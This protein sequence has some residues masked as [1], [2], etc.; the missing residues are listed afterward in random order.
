MTKAEGPPA[1][2]WTLLEPTLREEGTFPTVVLTRSAEVAAGQVGLDGSI[3]ECDRHTAHVDLGLAHTPVR[4]V[5]V[6]LDVGRRLHSLDSCVLENQL[7][8][9]EP[10]A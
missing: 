9:L 1:L 7:L 3:A 10:L 2:P 5:D 6:G 8:T 4:R